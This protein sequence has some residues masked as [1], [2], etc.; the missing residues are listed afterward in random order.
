M[1]SSRDKKKI[2]NPT[3]SK[4]QDD[5]CLV[6]WKYPYA[7]KPKNK[8]HFPLKTYEDLQERT[9][10][11]PV[12]K[13][14]K[15]KDDIDLERIKKSRKL[16]NVNRFYF[17]KNNKPGSPISELEALCGAFY[18]FIAPENVP[19]THAVYDDDWCSLLIAN[20][21]PNAFTLDEF[22]LTTNAA[23]VRFGEKLYYVNKEK[24]ECTFLKNF[25]A[26]TLKRF[27]EELDVSELKDI[28]TKHRVLSNEELRNITD[29]TGH[30]HGDG[31]LDDKFGYETHR[32]VGVSSKAIPN[33]R[34]NHDVPLEEQD[35]IIELI[36]DLI[37]EET[38][39][40][41][42]ELS[43]DVKEL[44][45]YL[46]KVFS[47]SQEGY[48]SSGV[49]YVRDLYNF[50]WNSAYT[51]VKLRDTLTTFTNSDNKLKF[52]P[53]S[54]QALLEFLRNRVTHIERDLKDPAYNEELVFLKKTA[55][56]AEKLLD[57]VMQK[58]V[59]ISANRKLEEAYR[60][61][62]ARGIDILSADDNER[63]TCDGFSIKIKDLKNYRIVKRLAVALV[64]RYLMQDTDGHNQN[65][66]KD[67]WLI[68]FDMAKLRILFQFREP[69][70]WD[71]RLR[72]PTE[73][74]FVITERDIANFPNIVDAD[75]Y[76]WPTKATILTKSMAK[77]ISLV[78][79]VRENF[80]EKKDNDTFKK[81]ATNP[82]FVFHK[83][84][85]LLKYIL[86]DRKMYQTIGKFHLRDDVMYKDWNDGKVKN[87]LDEIVNDEEA[88]IQKMREV[89]VKMPEF[90]KFMAY[91]G[92]YVMN[93]I[94]EEFLAYRNKYKAKI[95]E[96]PH[97]KEVVN[98]IN[99]DEIH[100][101]YLKIFKECGADKVKKES[102]EPTT[103][104]E[105]FNPEFSTMLRV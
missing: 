51:S 9:S 65:M 44:T 14:L 87:L 25:N 24:R 99:L 12:N 70:F 60:L 35:T 95:K 68:D 11:H 104:I 4:L 29:L 71:R 86:T 43:N 19:S 74:T 96:K 67:G 34:T 26:E 16:E 52:S 56:S 36:K 73:R 62:I 105:P 82:V 101:N 77:K 90:Q 61:A 64:T 88:R 53:Q 58:S 39:T 42:Q 91:N 83:Y 81:L 21:A 102:S 45:S 84:K 41:C 69:D 5:F 57:L 23:Y 22:N 54:I 10:A 94:K 18:A 76:Y 40:Q 47:T 49:Q 98:A 50:F 46:E 28:A 97:F 38:E 59:T 13:A 27:D 72:Q 30:K 75:F 3:E 85:T 6:D 2:E 17:F 15:A 7:A 103:Q 32:F 48:V 100:K 33:F 79:T 80:F 63:I 92:K 37:E 55:N 66:S 1:S 78:Y 31:K 89:L 8:F 20:K 93:L